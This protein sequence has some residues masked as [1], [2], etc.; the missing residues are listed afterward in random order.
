MG[1]G[2]GQGAAG[3]RTP[4][5]LG[6]S[7]R[8]QARAALELLESQCYCTCK[9]AALAVVAE[10]SRARV[11]GAFRG[12]SRQLSHVEGFARV[13]LDTHARLGQQVGGARGRTD[14]GRNGRGEKIRGTAMSVSVSVSVSLPCL[15]ASTCINPSCLSVVYL[16]VCLLALS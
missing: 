15:L 16:S 4:S 12:G 5:W 14:R 3:I 9:S 7:R 1:G 13:A 11:R 6:F 2:E 8:T 10:L